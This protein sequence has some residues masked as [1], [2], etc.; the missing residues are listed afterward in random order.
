MR[1]VIGCSAEVPDGVALTNGDPAATALP[2][3]VVL[4]SQLKLEQMPPKGPGVRFSGVANDP[5]GSKLRPFWTVSGGLSSMP[6]AGDPVDSGATIQDQFTF[7]PTVGG[8]YTVFLTVYD[9]LGLFDECRWVLNVVPNNRP[10]IKVFSG[11][12]IVEF[13]RLDETRSD[14]RRHDPARGHRH[15]AG[16]SGAAGGGV[17][18]Q[19]HGADRLGWP[20]ALS[21]G[22]G[23]TVRRI[24]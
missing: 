15:A 10:E 18:H 1:P 20:D 23:R 8:D 24:A 7:Q 16:C 19:R 12:T 2:S 9:N 21:Y 5:E 6:V 22:A 14:G 3:R 4:V 11:R 13:G 17:A